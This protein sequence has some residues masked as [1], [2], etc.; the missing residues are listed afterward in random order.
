MSLPS[1][2]RSIPKLTAPL[3]YVPRFVS[4]GSLAQIVKP[5]QINHAPILSTSVEN[6]AIRATTLLESL[7]ISLRDREAIVSRASDNIEII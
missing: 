3:E 2:N 7:L 4:V 1:F 6:N 5:I